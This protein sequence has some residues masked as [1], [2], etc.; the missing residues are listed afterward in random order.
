MSEILLKNIY[1]CYEDGMEAISDFNL[2]I[3]GKEFVVF[4]GPSG[5][6]K[7]TTLRMIAGLE[8]ISR[9]E[10]WMD[11]VKINKVKPNHRDIAMVFQNYA[12]YPHMSV[13]ENIAYSM[14]LKKIPKSEIRKTVEQV[15]DLLDIRQILESRPGQL[16][17]G[18]KQRVAI[19]RAIVRNPK[20]FLMDEPLSNLDAKLRNKMR[21]EIHSL[22]QMLNTTF[23]YVTHDQ[24]EAMTLGTKIV[25]M[26][27]GII[28][29]V[30]SP[31][32]L[33]QYPANVF[34]AQFIGT[35]QMNLFDG[36]L[37]FQEER[38]YVKIDEMKVPLSDELGEQLSRQ[39]YIGKKVL[40]GVR[41]E[42]VLLDSES[43]ML[44]PIEGYELLGAESNIFLKYQNQRISVK[45]EGNIGVKREDIVGITL[46]G[47]KLHFF[48]PHTMER[49]IVSPL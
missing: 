21:K 12:L 49:I 30:A 36:E 23:I 39:N 34:V 19:G 2:E 41:P 3:S 6:G 25:V 17:G 45:T 16:S 47:T 48:N 5:C 1:K 4:V 46:N 7:S 22:Y 42:D 31:Q 27:D 35:P 33:Y 11:G 44:L 15:S 8:E 9:G 43:E 38:F 20:V 10:L 40:V 13:Y 37:I 32:E 28:Q 24:I 29:Q 14:K 26:K 18:Q